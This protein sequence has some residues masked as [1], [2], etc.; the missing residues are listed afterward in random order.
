VSVGG[1]GGCCRCC[2]WRPRR[3]LRRLGLGVGGSRRRRWPGG[4]SAAEAGRVNGSVVGQLLQ[5]VDV[6]EAIS[7]VRADRRDDNQRLAANA[8][9]RTTAFGMRRYSV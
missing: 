8:A 3:W 5:P 2:G 7:E 1:G 4:Y 9:V 6:T